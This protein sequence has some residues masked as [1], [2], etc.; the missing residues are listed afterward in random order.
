MIY[1]I[2]K[3]KG[4]KRQYYEYNL[5]CWN[6]GTYGFQKIELDNPKDP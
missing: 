3:E 2:R 4:N 5:T 1:K 6:K